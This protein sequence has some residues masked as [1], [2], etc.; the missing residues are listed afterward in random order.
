MIR[1]TYVVAL[2]LLLAC[3]SSKD[4]PS[5]VLK[6]EKTFLVGYRVSHKHSGS[7]IA[8]N[9]E[10][11]F[12]GDIITHKKISIFSSQATK[13]LDIPLNDVLKRDMIDD[14]SIVSL[15]TILVLSEHTNHLFYINRT[16]AIWRFVDLNPYLEKADPANRY[17][18]IS[19][20]YQDFYMKKSAFL[21]CYLIWN[22]PDRKSR[23]DQYKSYFSKVNQGPFIVKIP[24]L[25]ADSLNVI[26][27]LNG[28]FGRFTKTDEITDDFPFYY[29]TDTRLF[30]FSSFNDS[31][32]EVDPESLTV[33]GAHY[34]HSDQS[35]ISR[36]PIRIN[37]NNVNNYADVLKRTYYREGNI[38]RFFY[39]KGTNMFYICA[40]HSLKESAPNDQSSVNGKCSFI[41]LDSSFSQLNEITLD[42]SDF[43]PGFTIVS[44]EGIFIFHDNPKRPDYDKK[45]IKFSVFKTEHI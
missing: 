24:N 23:L 44:R 1:L 35:D 28:L 34:V 12:F 33:I 29:H 6:G 2:L 30:C 10:F 19:S 45:R 7:F 25:F 17:F 11:F 43:T 42:A 3:T 39:D 16:G 40:Y 36:K 22:E 27:G 21:R 9:Q 37:E 14:F 26:F 8:D 4:K 32:Y 38:N 13:V 20:M 41:L 18:L 15:D 5:L 31:I